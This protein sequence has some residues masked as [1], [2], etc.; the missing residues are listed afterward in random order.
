MQVWLDSV[1]LFPLIGLAGVLITAVFARRIAALTGLGVPLVLGLGFSLSLIAAATL[2]PAPLGLSGACLRDVDSPL[3]RGLLVRSDRMLNTWL[4]V[5]LGLFA[6]A[7]AVRRAWVLLAA[8]AVP[9]VVEGLQRLLPVLGRR[10]QFQDL[11]DNMWGLILGALVGFG[12][13]V[14]GSRAERT[15]R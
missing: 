1:P 9:F 4:F 5:P 15:R 2:S 14:L 8:F 7:A 10:C 12:I 6:G 11:V 3:G 13:A